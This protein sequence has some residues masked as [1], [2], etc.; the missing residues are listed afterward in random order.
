M[1]TT[2]GAAALGKLVLGL[3][4]PHGLPRLQTVK[5]CSAGGMLLLV[6]GCA[7]AY[8]NVPT[9]AA[10]GSPDYIAY[11]SLALFGAAAAIGSVCVILSET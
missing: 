2:V 6:L 5:V 1:G 4:R 8:G 7:L 9:T 11:T 10:E 3:V